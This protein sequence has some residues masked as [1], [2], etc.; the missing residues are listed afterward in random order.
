M[1]LF[2]VYILYVNALAE[3]HRKVTIIKTIVKGRKVGEKFIKKCAKITIFG[4]IMP[5]DS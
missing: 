4:A 5:E 1:A 3:Y 2:G